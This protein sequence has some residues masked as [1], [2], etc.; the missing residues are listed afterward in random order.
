[1]WRTA[2]WA[3]VLLRG[4]EDCFPFKLRVFGCVRLILWKGAMAKLAMALWD[5]ATREP[6]LGGAHRAREW[7]CGSSVSRSL[8]YM[9]VCSVAL[10]ESSVF[11]R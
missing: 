5:W 7:G 11:S 2:A 6:V 10:S 4:V 8:Q 3:V 1:M 9:I